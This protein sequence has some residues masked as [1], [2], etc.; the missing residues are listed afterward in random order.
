MN[1]QLSQ[2]IDLTMAEKLQLVEDL[3]DHIA[4]SPEQLPIPQWQKDELD[5]RRKRFLAN[6]ESG[7]PW[8]EAKRRI[9]DRNG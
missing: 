8:H 6:P 1:P 7:I 4:E 5:L 3:W 9:L 2:L